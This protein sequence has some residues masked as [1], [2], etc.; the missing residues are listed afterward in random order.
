MP[1]FRV[2]SMTESEAESDSE[3]P[4][5]QMASMI[6]AADE[7]PKTCLYGITIFIDDHRIF[8][9]PIQL[10]ETMKATDLEEEAFQFCKIIPG[11]F[12]DPK[13]SS[14]TD[15]AGL[16]GLA[17]DAHAFVHLRE[18]PNNYIRTLADLEGDAPLWEEI[19]NYEFPDR[20]AMQVS[21]TEA[22]MTAGKK[23]E[24]D[25]DEEP[26]A[27]TNMPPSQRICMRT[28][29]RALEEVVWGEGIEKTVDASFKG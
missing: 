23:R 12:G 22:A 3:S 15:L 27:V 19:L 18:P 8:Y 28:I 21:E 14:A 9:Q 17:T 11:V 29:S 1:V 4:N 20:H 6:A 5:A 24:R 25:D 7:L 13:Y 2:P 26:K 10:W 16:M